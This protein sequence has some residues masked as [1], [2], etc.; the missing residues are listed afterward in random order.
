MQYRIVG[1][2]EFV[3]DLLPGGKQPGGAPANFAYHV[4]CL[5]D[6]GIVVT[7][8]GRDAL[9]EE[10]LHRLQSHGLSTRYVQLPEGRPT[11]TVQ[12]TVDDEGQ[13]TFVIREG[14]AWDFLEYTERLRELGRRA[15]A[16]CFGNLAQRAPLSRQTTR[17][18]LDG[19]PDGVLRIYDVNLRQD[20]FEADTVRE[21][22]ARA[23]L[24]KLN[25]QELA[26]VCRL[27][28]LDPGSGLE[29]GARSLLAAFALSLVCVT[30]GCSGSLLVPRRGES[31]SHPGYPS[32]VADTVGAGDA[33]TAA[34]TCCYL[35]GASL[36]TV[37]E[38]GNR[39]GSYVA[40]QAGATPE[41]SRALGRELAE[42]LG[43]AVEGA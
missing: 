31:C 3:W 34:L 4:T 24:V 22:L 20:F 40:S 37:S 41:G 43:P 27:L 29:E 36:E 35:R 16:V 14:V 6:E 9:G 5:G 17:R 10:A 28:G 8:V 19:L 11:G 7:G 32:E 2:G 38:A 23:D 25:D 30:R 18:F 42:S 12:V 33:F 39:L 15:D 1:V 21:S 13:P 26:P